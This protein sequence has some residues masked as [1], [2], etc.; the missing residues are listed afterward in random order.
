[1][2]EDNP[3]WPDV[4]R[5][6]AERYLDHAVGKKQAAHRARARTVLL[7]LTQS[8]HAQSYPRMDSALFMLADVHTQLGKPELARQSYQLLIK[9]YPKSTFVPSALLAF[10]DYYFEQAQMENALAFYDKVVAFTDAA[11]APYAAWKRGWVFYNLSRPQEALDAFVQAARHA[12]A[13]P[14][15]RHAIRDSVRVYA[16]VG[17]PDKAAAFYGKLA[18]DLMPQPLYWLADHYHDLGRSADEALI[19]AALSRDQGKGA[20]PQPPAAP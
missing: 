4:A 1:M 20:A 9:N 11:V 2:A 3:S 10:G 6:L 19:R 15:R 12:K 7:R 17:K 13:G 14:V 16:D 5:Q 18:K 8:K